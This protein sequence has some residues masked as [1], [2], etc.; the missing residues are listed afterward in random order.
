MAAPST[1]DSGPWPPIQETPGGFP[2]AP[3]DND[4]SAVEST[5]Y[6][7]SQ[8]VKAR[9]SEYV[10][11]KSIKIKIGTWNVA[12][13]NGAERDLGGWFVD[14]KGIHGLTEN[15]SG[16]DEDPMRQSQAGKE[17]ER[18]KDLETVE[19]QEARFS[20][21]QPTLPNE[22]VAAVPAGRDIGI[23]V[24]GLQEVVDI[25]SASEA[26]RPYTDPSTARRWKTAMENALP[27]GYQQ[28]AEEQLLGLLILVYAAPDV[29]PTIS[30]VS[31]TSVGTGLLGYMGNKG[32]VSVRLV[33]GETTRIIFVDCHLAAGSDKAAL[34]RR[35]WDA[36]QVVSRTRFD[37]ITDGAADAEGF[38]D[39]IG[40]EDF[41][42]WFGDLNYR[43]EDIPGEDVRRLLLLHTKNE[44]DLNNSSKRKID[45]ELGYVSVQT[46]E[47]VN[48]PDS[49][50]ELSL[51][52]KSD[53]ASLQTTLQSLLPH[54]QLLKQQKI[55]KAFHDG[56][57]EGEIDFLPTYK[58]DVGSVGMFDSG[59]K[60]R[61]P[62][63]CDR[64]LFRTRRDRL[65]ALEQI[66][67]EEKDRKRDEE[68]KARGIEEASQEDD[69]LFDY[70]PENDDDAVGDDHDNN[71]DRPSSE[72]V[73]TKAGFE[74]MISIDHY[75]SHQ[76][77]LSSDHK[78]LDAVFTLTYDSVVP[79]LR[80]HVHQEVAKQLDKAENEGRPTVTIVVDHPRE[81]ASPSHDVNNSSQSDHH[82]IN[83][84][85]VRYRRRKVRS[86]TIAN[87]GSV[88]ATVSF[89]DRPIE[90]GAKAGKSPPWLQIH[91][92]K[93][94]DNAN[95]NPSALHEYSL[96]P[97]ETAQVELAVDI[98]SLKLVQRLNERILTMEDILVLRVNNGRDH[99]IPVKGE[100]MQSCLCR[101]IDDL[102]VLPESG[103]QKKTL[104]AKGPQSD[105]GPSAE[106]EHGNENS[107][108][109]ESPVRVS[110][111]RELFALTE[112]IQGF[113]TRSIAEWDM[114]HE[115]S[116]SKPWSFNASGFNGWPFDERARTLTFSPHHPAL[117]SSIFEA[118]DTGTALKDHFPDDAPSLLR[119]EALSEAICIFLSS[120]V[121]GVI[122]SEIWAD[123]DD[124]LRETE[125]DKVQMAKDDLQTLILESLSS[126]PA[127][128]VSLTFL[129]FML[130]KII[131]EILPGS[132]SISSNVPAGHFAATQPE[133]EPPPT[134]PA[135]TMS[136]SS[137]SATSMFSSLSLRGRR[138]RSNTLSSTSSSAAGSGPDGQ[139]PP[140]ATGS[141]SEPKTDL[142]LAMIRAYTVNFAD[143]VI[144]S[145]SPVPLK[146]K[147]KRSLLERKRKALETLLQ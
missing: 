72:L 145:G 141:N 140:P 142:R 130:N 127:H 53:P 124:R 68:M 1:E 27:S 113:L 126:K 97:G 26:L 11:K 65:R 70:D 13:T 25:S 91:V 120:L 28:I 31:S 51:D 137:R 118:L 39:G 71:Q 85:E 109:S 67:Q 135:S 34:E 101:T 83:F 78:P 60:K 76:R 92:E 56:W 46:S 73:T 21:H 30:S 138:T 89:I 62:S 117:M 4:D 84:G 108:K 81:E 133:T 22:D 48:A 59:E 122:P 119:L 29:A 38:G 55:R 12:S 47:D 88:I 95:S 96:E 98:D 58:Y 106:N 128:H 5:P 66:E 136:P 131:N 14:G 20:K 115:P 112:A 77:V 90:E 82:S 132:Q 139:Y 41:C 40:D 102:V 114:T 144:R 121:D 23:Y 35:N 18:P 19:H 43:L 110:A 2:V 80:A 24:L 99:F 16:L 93:T 86:M 75:S 50:D 57:R 147:D 8:A 49:D 15:L 146:E 42:F 63:W 134:D 36:A 103:I 107:C 129:V 64:I 111:P 44:Y 116:E 3:H 54:D 74:D 10:R 37:P 7:L 6:S 94:S 123:I 17:N 45:S 69:I 32:A 87:T 125:K 9:K 100:W 143:A 61:G 105:N 79:E 33:L 52:P 104:L